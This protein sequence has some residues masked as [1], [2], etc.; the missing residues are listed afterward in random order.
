MN[1]FSLILVQFSHILSQSRV[2]TVFV[3][4]AMTSLVVLKFARKTESGIS[5]RGFEQMK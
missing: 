1:F 5:P 4:W 3:I 2:I